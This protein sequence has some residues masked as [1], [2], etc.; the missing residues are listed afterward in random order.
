MKL[1]YLVQNVINTIEFHKKNEDV[2]QKKN[3][4]VDKI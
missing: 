3:I 2:L 1:S 4:S